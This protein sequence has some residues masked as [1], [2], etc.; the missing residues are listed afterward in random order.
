MVW[1]TQTF[2]VYN[3]QHGIVVVVIGMLKLIQSGV[4][5]VVRGI[6]QGLD[7]AGKQFEIYPNV[8]AC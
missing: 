3:K 2:A 6:G 5:K 4:G 1:Q 7:S 8:D